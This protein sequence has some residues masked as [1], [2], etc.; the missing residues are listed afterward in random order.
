MV[1]LLILTNWKGKNYNSIL[2]IVNQLIKI[3]N[4]KL[5]KATIN[6]FELVEVIF[7]VIVWRY[8]FFNLIISNR[9]LQFTFKFWLLLCYFFD[10]K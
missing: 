7:N 6:I 5:V 4:Y 2:V 9:G 3:V 8:S 1:R 10:I